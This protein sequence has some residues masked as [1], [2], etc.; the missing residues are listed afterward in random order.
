MRAREFFLVHLFSTVSRLFVGIPLIYAGFGGF[1][2]ALGMAASSLALTASSLAL[3]GLFIGFGRSGRGDLV[4]VLRVGFSNYL[5]TLVSAL[6]SG[7]VVTTRTS[8]GSWGCWRSLHI[9]HDLH[10]PGS[11]TL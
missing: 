7:G 2:A 1:G 11:N 5:Q 6:T 4:E 10:G 9:P 3:S 8:R